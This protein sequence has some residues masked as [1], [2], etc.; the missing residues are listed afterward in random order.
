MLIL[1][2]SFFVKVQSI[3]IIIN[4]EICR[5]LICFQLLPT[6]FRIEI[7]K[8]ERTFLEYPFQCDSTKNYSRATL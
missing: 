8:N 3:P 6:L 2:S 4:V 7:F 1:I 5:H